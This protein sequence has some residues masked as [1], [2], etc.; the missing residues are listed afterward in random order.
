MQSNYELNNNILTNFS[1]NHN[2]TNYQNQNQNQNQFEID[3]YN[4]FN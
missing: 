2:I 3:K 4:Y 1:Q